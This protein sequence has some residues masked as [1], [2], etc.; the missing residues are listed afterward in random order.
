MRIFW[1]DL[2]LFLAGNWAFV[3]A[4]VFILAFI[5]AHLAGAPVA[6]RYTL[7]GIGIVSFLIFAVKGSLRPV[8]DESG[9]QLTV[10]EA[11]ERED[12]S[13]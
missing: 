10:K 7:G 11:R 5:I 1:M 3:L 12:K 2:R 8:T 13:D 6:L 4:G 9:R